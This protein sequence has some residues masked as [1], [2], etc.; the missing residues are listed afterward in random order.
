MDRLEQLLSIFKAYGLKKDQWFEMRA[1][2][3][4]LGF[5]DTQLCMNSELVKLEAK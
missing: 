4:S 3:H 5:C 1:L 2:A